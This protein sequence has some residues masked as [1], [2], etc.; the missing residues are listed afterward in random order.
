MN[1]TMTAD[2]HLDVKQYTYEEDGFGSDQYDAD[3]E[4]PVVPDVVVNYDSSK[5]ESENGASLQAAIDGA[6][7]GDVIAVGAGEYDVTY[8]GG[9]QSENHY[10]WIQNNNVTII[11]AEDGSTVINAKYTGTMNGNEQQTV[12]ITGKNVTLKNLTINPIEGYD[13]KTVELR[14]NAANV[15]IEN[16]TI[17]GNLHIGGPN[18]GSYTI[19]NNTFI[20]D[21]ASIGRCQRAP[22][23]L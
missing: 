18:V 21:D 11:G 5:S 20:N 9:H 1:K 16:C 7:D 6:K 4:W 14:D 13:N 10:L 22:A 19:C 17:D 15:T 3:A 2:I 12:L 8:M 23:T